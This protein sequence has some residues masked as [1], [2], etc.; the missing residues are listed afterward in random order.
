MNTI[1]TGK[2]IIYHSDR[3]Q[4][5]SHIWNRPGWNAAKERI[6]PPFNDVVPRTLITQFIWES[7]IK[8]IHG[9]KHGD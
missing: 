1:S 8:E 2:L 9:D 4:M 7:H 3:S 6:R 5:I